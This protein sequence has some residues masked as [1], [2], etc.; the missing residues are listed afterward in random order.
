MF[1]YEKRKSYKKDVKRLSSALIDANL[2]AQYVGTVPVH[3]T[4]TGNQGAPYSLKKVIR[5]E[6]N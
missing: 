6:A 2:C 4:G 5:F 3:E 1:Y